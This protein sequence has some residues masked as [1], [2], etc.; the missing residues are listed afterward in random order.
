M[1]KCCG[2]MAI[3]SHAMVICFQNYRDAVSTYSYGQPLMGITGYVLQL[4]F[5][6]CRY[7]SSNTYKTNKA[8]YSMKNPLGQLLF[9]KKSPVNRFAGNIYLSL[10][11]TCPMTGKQQSKL[12]MY[13]A[14]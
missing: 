11:K 9:Q 12:N 8:F 5:V 2:A 4:R 14:L 1:V 13:G 7:I 10:F 3:C 6:F